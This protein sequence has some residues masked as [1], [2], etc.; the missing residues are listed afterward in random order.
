MNATAGTAASTSAYGTPSLTKDASG[1]FEV[2]PSGHIDT[3]A[4][5]AKV[6]LAATTVA[7]STATTTVVKAGVGK[8]H[9]INVI[10]GTLGNITVYDNTAGS[11]T[12]IVPTAT[13]TGSVM[14]V[15]NRPVAT[16]ITVV[17]AGATVL[18][19]GYR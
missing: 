10:G 18:V 6:E 5:V 11:G 7:I 1:N 16:G 3:T 14:W 4:N 9:Y 19:V 17:T 15:F 12:V 13:P 8:L 2:E